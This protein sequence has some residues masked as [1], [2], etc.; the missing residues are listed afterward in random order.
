[1]PNLS[2]ASSPVFAAIFSPSSAKSSV[3]PTA[4]GV[5]VVGS[6]AL[7]VAVV[8]VVVGS[9]ALGAAAAGGGG[10]AAAGGGGAAAPPPPLI[11]SAPILKSSSSP[12][13]LNLPWSFPL[14]SFIILL[15]CWTLSSLKFPSESTILGKSCSVTTFSKASLPSSDKFL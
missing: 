6:G 10:A 3:S 7:G 2:A 8:G 13:T 14:T 9:G 4:F 11:P 15:C 1:M 5:V 12:T